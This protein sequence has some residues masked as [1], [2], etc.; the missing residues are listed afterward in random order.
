M[1]RLQSGKAVAEIGKSIRGRLRFPRSVTAPVVMRG[2]T[3]AEPVSGA[4]AQF[5]S[6]VDLSGSSFRRGFDFSSAR[7]S[8]PFL[9]AGDPQGVR[10]TTGKNGL[11]RFALSRF[12]D[13]AIFNNA[14]F[15]GPVD[16]SNAEFDSGAGFTRAVFSR[17]AQFAFVS[18]RG[19]LLTQTRGNDTARAA[20]VQTQGRSSHPSGC[21]TSQCP[22][23]SGSCVV[24]SDPASCWSAVF[25]RG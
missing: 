14:T 7:F 16:F 10:A 4:G 21:R 12:G 5:G 6:L 9:M 11:A 19:P 18:F 3:F 13:S 20:G 22:W 17:P 15:K 1:R 23:P 8:G 25:E 24:A 2:D